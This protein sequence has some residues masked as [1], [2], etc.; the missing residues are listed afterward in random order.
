[1]LTSAVYLLYF[2]LICAVM[3]IPVITFKPFWGSVVQSILVED[4][5][6][7]NSYMGSLTFS[8]DVLQTIYPD[9]AQWMTFGIA[10]LSFTGIGFLIY[11]VN[12]LSG[13]Y[14]LGSIVASF[15]VL[16]D[17]V[18]RWIV[19]RSYWMYYVSPVSWSSIEHW[20]ILG[21]ERPLN[22]NIIIPV[23]V[24]ICIVLFVIAGIGTRR[25]DITV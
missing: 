8:K 15:F 6:V 21:M 22:Q 19:L 13:K 25:K 4:V 5:D 2:C 24:I 11:A 23:N 16:L 9:S 1:M 12:Q 17:P 3:S 14:R 18:I 10:W 7:L 20:K